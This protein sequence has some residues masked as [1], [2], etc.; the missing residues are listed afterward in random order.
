MPLKLNQEELPTINL[1]S[2]IDVVFLL[3]IFF[4]VG[5]RFSDTESSISVNLP[6]INSNSL[7]STV[8]STKIVNI[9]GD[10]GIEIDSRRVGIGEV[11]GVI[12][13]AIRN[14]PQT[15]VVVRAD[16]RIPMQRSVEVMSAVQLSGAQRI[17]IALANQSGTTR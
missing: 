9:L 3:L 17:S 15:T 13:S 1:T 8:A 10:G 11:A 7:G 5:T 2:M 12:G 4:M 16:A 6:R 14:N